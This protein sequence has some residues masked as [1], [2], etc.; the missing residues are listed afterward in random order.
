MLRMYRVPGNTLSIKD[1]IMNQ[2][3]SQLSP[4]ISNKDNKFRTLISKENELR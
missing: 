2:I 1:K 4:T 3:K